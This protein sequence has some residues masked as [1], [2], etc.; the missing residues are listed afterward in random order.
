ML[1]SNCEVGEISL[2]GG[3]ATFLT[4]AQIKL[5]LHVY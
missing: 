2:G 1:L 3:G 5:K 4:G